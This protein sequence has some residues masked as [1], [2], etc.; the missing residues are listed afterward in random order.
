MLRGLGGV[1]LGLP[2]LEAMAAPARLPGSRPPVRFAALYMPNG[3]NVNAWA[4]LGSGRDYALSPT[5]EPLADLKDRIVV[6][7]NLWNEATKGG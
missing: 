6:M 1:S 2:W 7:S 3:V 5:L 4:P